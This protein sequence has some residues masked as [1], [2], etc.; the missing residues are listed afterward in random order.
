MNG[1]RLSQRNH[2][3]KTGFEQEFGLL[4]LEESSRPIGQLAS[5]ALLPANKPKNRYHDILPYDASRVK[6]C[7]CMY[8]WMYVCMH[9]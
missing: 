9:V 2:S 4:G 1:H 6:V 7:V 8:V 3:G 5:V